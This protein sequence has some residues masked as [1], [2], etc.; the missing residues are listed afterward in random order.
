MAD[1]EASLKFTVDSTKAVEGIEK[2]DEAIKETAADVAKVEAP[3]KQATTA[4]EQLGEA[5]KKVVEAEKALAAAGDSPRALVKAAAAATI[6]VKDLRDSLAAAGKPIP[7]AVEQS[8][9]KIEAG[10]AA[11]AKRASLLKEE[12]DNTRKAGNLAAQGAEQL[13]SAFGSVESVFQQMKAS[14]GGLSSTLGGLGLQAAGLFAAFQL[15]KQIA[16]E[17]ADELAKLVDKASAHETRMQAAA[18]QS[19]K[20]EQ[21]LRLAE[22]GTI[23]FSRTVDG[24]IKN[25]DNY[26]LAAGKASIETDKFGKTLGG[27]TPPASLEAIEAKAA[28]MGAELS[29]VATKSAAEWKNWAIEN[30]ST[31]ASMEAAFRRFGQAVPEE[32][33]R[34]LDA[35]RAFREGNKKEL[36]AIAAS[37][38]DAF[39]DSAAASKIL[40][41]GDRALNDEIV[42]ILSNMNEQILRTG[43]VGQATLTAEGALQRYQVAHRMTA[44][45]VANL[46]AAQQKLLEEQKAV[47]DGGLGPMDTALSKVNVNLQEAAAATMTYAQAIRALNAAAREGEKQNAIDREKFHAQAIQE[48]AAAAQKAADMFALQAEASDAAGAAAVKASSDFKVMTILQTELMRATQ[49]QT[50]SLERQVAVFGRLREEMGE[51]ARGLEDYAATLKSAYESGAVSFLQFN[52][53]IQQAINQLEILLAKNAGT[54][55]AA[56]LEKM[57]GALR[58]LKEAVDMGTIKP[59]AR[60]RI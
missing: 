46:V 17:L 10:A 47:I 45:E 51:Q 2:V 49:G 48:T 18:L 25:Y 8:L 56:D 7:P 24:L 42:K 4:L 19:Q 20:W 9:K 33:R 1:Q 58:E 5:G 15:G 52:L 31:L 3:A 59:E 29:N 21:A 36:D 34:A 22:S 12:L 32:L 60:L 28:R 6:Q 55:F 53:Q 54:R 23:E 50:E 26:I 16:K 27:L 38:K 13:T 30:E 37:L 57:I 11:A 35:A 14:S 39:Q 40:A 44:D 43:D 41:D